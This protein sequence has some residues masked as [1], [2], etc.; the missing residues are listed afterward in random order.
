MRI[1]RT[2]NRIRELMSIFVTQMQ[3][4]TSQND[5]YVNQLAENVLLPLFK[6]AYG[7]DRLRNLNENERRN[8][9]AIDLA[10]DE[11]RVAIQVTVT[12][13]SDKIKDTL[14][15]FIT[16][17][18][19]EK[20]DR[21]IVYIL[22]QKQ[23]NYSGHGFA[24]IA[25]GKLNFN[26]DEDILDYRDFLSTANGLT[27][28]LALRIEHI[29]E[30][31][32]GEGLTTFFQ[33]EPISQTEEVFLN[34]LALTLPKE[35]FVAQTDF[36]RDEVVKE[37][38][39]RGIRLNRMSG[40]RDVIRA[41][42]EQQGLGFGTDWVCHEGKLITFHDLNEIE[43][44]LNK[45]IDLGTAEIF[46]PASFYGIDEDHER[47]FKQLLWRTLQQSLY[48]LG[49]RWQNEDKLFIFGDLEG[50]LHRKVPWAGWSD[51]RTVYRRTMKDNKPDE[52]L[53][54]E[55]FGFR[56]QFR[57][58]GDQWYLLITP[59][60]FASYDGYHKDKFGNFVE[61]KKLNENNTH[62][63]NHARF[64]AHFLKDNLNKHSLPLF[65]E[66]AFEEDLSSK[67]SFLTFGEFVSFDNAPALD[68]KAYLPEK[69]NSSSKQQ[70][71]SDS[72][73][74]RQM[75]LLEL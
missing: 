46:T 72:D 1:S 44:P 3:A 12:P 74:P 10:D 2:Q 48:H 73:Q 63:C 60:W 75:T 34:L 59:E 23:R 29:L 57:R 67:P 7:W 6:I 31:H 16:H 71:E 64:V 37:S 19:Y 42:L 24:E 21:L 15:M 45:V 62:V 61:W 20:Y 69:K 65:G 39:H 41:A 66:D 36:D 22:T 26:K 18:L 38:K 13:D 25:D 28:E 47:V 17:K 32:F 35:L 33:Y 11:K 43:L 40:D 55:H 8:Y 54:D 27:F 49:V 4:S 14:T 56:T 51:G 53:R 70:K 52:V 9:P 5:T 58:F 50:E 30:Q 68:D